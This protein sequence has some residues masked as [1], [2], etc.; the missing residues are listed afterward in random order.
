MP[1][2]LIRGQTRR[3]HSC[4]EIQKG[5]ETSVHVEYVQSQA[6]SND[7]MTLEANSTERDQLLNFYFS[8]LL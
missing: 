5:N 3:R 2:K 7:R 8:F 4:K 1:V 6:V